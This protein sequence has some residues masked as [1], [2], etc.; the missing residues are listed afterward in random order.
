M[1]DRNRKLY[2][3]NNRLYISN[4]PDE[5]LAGCVFYFNYVGGSDR[6]LSGSDRYLKH[7]VSQGPK[8]LEISGGVLYADESG[9]YYLE[10][11]DFEQLMKNPQ[12]IKT[13]V[14]V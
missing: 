3:L 8:A 14:P 2:V 9:E 4:D 7:D 1:S 10:G 12:I 11:A 5:I 13:G 6:Y